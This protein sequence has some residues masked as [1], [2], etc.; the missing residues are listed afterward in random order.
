MGRTIQSD[1]YSIEPIDDRDEDDP[2]FRIDPILSC[3][4]TDFGGED[5]AI[6]D[7]DPEPELAP[8]WVNQEG[9]EA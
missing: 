7:P 4:N 3:S 1:G 9:K 2:D 6:A 5:P 8:A